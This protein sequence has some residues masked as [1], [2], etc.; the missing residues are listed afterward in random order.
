[1]PE[2]RKSGSPEPGI[3]LV[4]GWGCAHH[5]EGSEGSIMAMIDRGDALG[6]RYR[7]PSRSA[8]SCLGAV[9]S[10]LLGFYG[11]EH[12]PTGE[13][14]VTF[15]FGGLAAMKVYL[16]VIVGVLVVVQVFT[17]LVD[18]RA[19]GPGG[20][21]LARRRAQALGAVAILVSLPVAYHCLWSLGFQ[22]TD[23]R[24]VVHSVAGCVVYGALWPSWSACTRVAR[25]VAPARRGR[26][27]AGVARGRHLDRG[28]LVRRGVR[29]AGHEHRLLSPPRQ[30]AIPFYGTGPS[31]V[32]I[33][34]VE[35]R[36]TCRSMMS[37]KCGVRRCAWKASSSSY[38]S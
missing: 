27:A 25:P 26:L 10:L 1:M 38:R 5:Q 34:F 8:R 19:T 13:A 17:A 14:I 30:P 16:S 37:A 23:T 36:M 31:R 12:E 20:A 3:T 7:A 32:T 33:A 22:T 4:G 9:V 21:V 15:G 29:L 28:G 11:R 24:V 35:Q 6:C 18:V 2:H